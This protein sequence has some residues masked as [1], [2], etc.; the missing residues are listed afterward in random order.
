MHWGN[1]FRALQYRNY[2]L[3]FAGQITSLVGTWMQS[4]AL[5]WLVYRLTHDEFML[6]L[7]AF[8]G[9]IAI[10]VL[11][12]LGGIVADRYPRRRIVII[13]QALSLV[14]AVTLA[15]LT[16]SGHISVASIL[17]IAFL[18]GMINAF[19]IPARQAMIVQISSKA[20]LM[21][22]ISLNSAMFNA[23]RVIGPALAGIIVAWLGEAFCFSIN[24]ASF[25]AVIFCLA[26]M[27]LP[28]LPAPPVESAWKR[29]ADGVRYVRSSRPVR[30]VLFLMAATTLSAMPILVLAPFFADGIF[31]RGSAGL[32]FLSGAMGLGAIAG[33]LQIAQ[34]SHSRGLPETIFRSSVGIAITLALFA[35]SPWF[36][37]SL[38]IMTAVGFCVM[39]LNASANSLVQTLA[40]D[41]YRGRIMAFY[42][43]TVVGLSP[44]GSLAAGA[45]ASRLGVQPTVLVGSAICLCAGFA[46]RFSIKDQ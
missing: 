26:A 9:N 14:Q 28:S 23:A 12:P 17:G 22:A 29:L 19:E 25:L 33:A 43:M 3:F 41:E 31:H 24:A 7:T 1:T 45:L 35:V 40:P 46:F 8:C 18:L 5:S 38:A 2:R 20:D 30:A 15:A 39:R 16:A 34:R 44:F 21:N 4:V 27:R 36:G 10:F 37:L 42:T 11:G 32:G 13:A 6:G